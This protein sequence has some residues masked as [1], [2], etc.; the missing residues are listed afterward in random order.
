MEWILLDW[1]FVIVEGSDD[2]RTDHKLYISR[3]P[4]FPSY[5]IGGF[6]YVQRTGHWPEDVVLNMKLENILGQSETEIQE[7][8]REFAA[9]IFPE[10]KSITFTKEPLLRY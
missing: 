5:M 1:W 4:A 3:N 10:A 2:Q 8:C 6:V 7:K 9:Q